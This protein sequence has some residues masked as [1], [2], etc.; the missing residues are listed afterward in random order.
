MATLFAIAVTIVILGWLWFFVARPILEDFGVIAVGQQ[1]ES[2]NTSQAATP[3][4][5]PAQKQTDQT[6]QTDNADRPSVSAAS[7]R[8]PRLQLD[9]TKTAVVEV[10]V[11]NGWGVGEIRAVLKGD[12]NAFGA[13]V[14]AARQRL[15]ID[16][17]ERLLWVRDEAG[18]RVIPI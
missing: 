2:V 3:I 18:E 11:Y 9:R 14:E 6:D 5:E 4:Q 7:L 15:G 12:S 1:P 10:L 17:P 13:E 16:P 8:V